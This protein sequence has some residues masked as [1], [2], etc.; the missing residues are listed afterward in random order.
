MLRHHPNPQT[1]IGRALKKAACHDPQRVFPFAF[2]SG[3]PSN[4]FQ[5]TRPSKPLI[6][7]RF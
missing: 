7:I 3:I 1:H 6:S 4:P 2:L 5:L